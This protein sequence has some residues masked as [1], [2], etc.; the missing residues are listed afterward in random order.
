MCGGTWQGGLGFSGGLKW[1]RARLEP[2]CLAARGWVQG[3]R[4]AVAP[5]LP[6]VRLG[7]WG[8]LSRT[9]WRIDLF[10]SHGETRAGVR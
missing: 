3:L 4:P 6:S 1:P 5:A 7:S 10:R 2:G 8:H 9:M